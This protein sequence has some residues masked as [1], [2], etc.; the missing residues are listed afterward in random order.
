MTDAVLL[1]AF[2][3]PTAPDEIRPFLQNVVRGR[4][5]PPERLEA[6]A[7]HYEHIGGRSPLNELTFR[8]ADALRALL[9]DTPVYVGMRNWAPYIADTVAQMAA[10]GVGTALGLVLSPHANEASRERYVETVDAACA[11]V[12]AAAP[13]FRWPRSWH[14]HPLYVTA[15][16]DTLAT[17]M[18][19]LPEADRARTPVVFTAHSV[20][21]ATAE[22][23]PYV[24]ELTESV[25]LVAARLGLERWQIA[26][27]SRSGSPRDPWLEPDVNDVVRELAARGERTVVLSPI[28]FVCDHVEVLYDLDVEARATADALGVRLLRARAVND[29]AAFVQMLAEVVREHR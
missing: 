23:S 16:A 2:G 9:P 1:L 15:V 27:Q 3:G 14:D 11:A 28:G 13:A 8:Q 25:E 18:V 6:V 5:I 19:A 20:P 10:D 21:I 29:H 22:A 7:L 26:Y 12:G 17:A 4:R 24:R